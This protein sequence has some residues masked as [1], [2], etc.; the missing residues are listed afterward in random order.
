MYDK[1]RKKGL[2]QR[3]YYVIINKV[4][5]LVYTLPRR[6]TQYRTIT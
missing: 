1:A 5:H 2:P 3:L 6:Y 4:L